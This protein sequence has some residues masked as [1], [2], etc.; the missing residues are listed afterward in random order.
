MEVYI[1]TM[2]SEL[3][4]ATGEYLEE[5][6]K[7]L[8]GGPMKGSL[9]KDLDVPV[10]KE[11][12]AILCLKEE[13]QQKKRTDCINCAYCVDVCNEQLLPTRLAK[14]ALAGNQEQFVQLGGLECCECGS[15]SYICP[16]NR[17]LT[18]IIRMMKE[19]IISEKES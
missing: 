7:M 16:S 4:A 17:P 5:P 1:G 10:T 9:L 15:C 3:V 12:S 2:L 8:C 6:D 18:Q 14:Y 19:Q 13:I 11:I